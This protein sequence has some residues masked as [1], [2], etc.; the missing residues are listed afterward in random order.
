MP[1]AASYRCRDRTE[2]EQVGL[3]QLK[4]VVKRKDL[5][6][7]PGMNDGLFDV[8]RTTAVQVAHQPGRMAAQRAGLRRIQA[9]VDRLASELR[10][11]ENAKQA[12]PAPANSTCQRHGRAPAVVLPPIARPAEKATATGLHGQHGVS[13]QFDA[14]LAQL[15]DGGERAQPKRRRGVRKKRRQRQQTTEASAVDDVAISIALAPP[16]AHAPI[17]HRGGDG[18]LRQGGEGVAM[19]REHERALAE[20]SFDRGNSSFFRDDP[21]STLLSQ[22]KANANAH[23][24]WLSSLSLTQM[25]AEAEAS[26]HRKA[27]QRARLNEAAGPGLVTLAPPRSALRPLD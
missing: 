7:L 18:S 26:E 25:M 10:A 5:P 22:G 4:G 14:F 8:L 16:Q 15:K 21:K 13:T 24:V 1:L 20:G 6:A 3:G 12:A 23:R 27:R 2:W 19:Q 17:C 11:L 9:D